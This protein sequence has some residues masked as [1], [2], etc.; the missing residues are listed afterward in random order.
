MDRVSSWMFKTIILDFQHLLQTKSLG[1]KVCTHE[2]GKNLKMCL[3]RNLDSWV[4][5]PAPIVDELSRSKAMTCPPNSVSILP[6]GSLLR[7]A[8]ETS[9]D[10]RLLLRENLKKGF[11]A[12]SS[13]GVFFLFLYY[14]AS[15]LMFFFST[16]ASVPKKDVYSGHSVV[17]ATRKNCYSTDWFAFFYVTKRWIKGLVSVP[18]RRGWAF[19]RTKF[20]L[21]KIGLSLVAAHARSS[22]SIR[23]GVSGITMQ[24][25]RLLPPLP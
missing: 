5:N 14:G 4:V 9:P 16:R 24:V 3:L 25:M 15:K 20:L 11:R 18:C 13:A 21:R 19:K 6:D 17:G 12:G 22:P 1:L 2:A 23:R 7:K 8:I 10:P